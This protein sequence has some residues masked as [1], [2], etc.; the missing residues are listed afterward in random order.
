MSLK[1]SVAVNISL[2]YHQMVRRILKDVKENNTD[3]FSCICI[4]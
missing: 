3:H 2:V 4:M 1:S